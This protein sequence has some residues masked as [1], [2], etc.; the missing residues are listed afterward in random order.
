MS[1]RLTSS[2]G[3]AGKSGGPLDSGPEPKV[4]TKPGRWIRIALAASLA[5]N[6]AVAGVLVGAALRGKEEHEARQRQA[7]EAAMLI[8]GAVFRE[9]TRKERRA[10][11]D[12]AL[13]DHPDMLSRRKDDVLRLLAIIRADEVDYEAL[14][15]EIARQQAHF[16]KVA[17]A[18]ESAWLTRLEDMDLS[19]RQR[20]ADR[21]ERHINSIRPPR[22]GKPGKPDKPRSEDRD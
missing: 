21:V 13:G 3:E 19:E 4:G 20:L 10:L 16:R 1:E 11:R 18:M 12:I 7:P 5:A 2:S 17:S 14:Q 9:L 8:S 15:A 22:G 6:L